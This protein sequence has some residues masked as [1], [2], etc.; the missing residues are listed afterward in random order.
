[1]VISIRVERGAAEKRKKERKKGGKVVIQAGRAAEHKVEQARSPRPRWPA[2]SVDRK[3][4]CHVVVLSVCTYMGHPQ[5]PILLRCPPIAAADPKRRR[6]IC[7]TDVARPVRT[8]YG[9]ILIRESVSLAV[10]RSACACA[11]CWRRSGSG[12]EGKRGKEGR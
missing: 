6:L 8:R 4:Y 2:K 7:L 11:C 12:G 9:G 1:M 10:S 3:K 5:S